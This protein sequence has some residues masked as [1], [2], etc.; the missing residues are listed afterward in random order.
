M[1]PS[2]STSESVCAPSPRH[3]SAFN[4]S[5]FAVLDTDGPLPIQSREVQWTTGENVEARMLLRLAEEDIASGS[6]EQFK[7]VVALMNE[8]ATD[9]AAETPDSLLIMRRIAADLRMSAINGSLPPDTRAVTRSFLFNCVMKLSSKILSQPNKELV[10]ESVALLAC[11]ASQFEDWEESY[12]ILRKQ[13]ILPINALYEES[14][15]SPEIVSLFPHLVASISAFWLSPVSQVR[16]ASVILGQLLKIIRILGNSHRYECAEQSL[17]SLL[18]RLR[19]PEL[20]PTATSAIGELLRTAHEKHGDGDP[21]SF[22]FFSKIIDPMETMKLAGWNFADAA[23]ADVWAGSI[24]CG[25]RIISDTFPHVPKPLRG[26]INAQAFGR[27]DDCNEAVLGRAQNSFDL[28][29]TEL[30][31]FPEVRWWLT[32][33][34][35]LWTWFCAVDD[36]EVRKEALGRQYQATRRVLGCRDFSPHDHSHDARPGS[37]SIPRSFTSTLSESTVVDFEA[38]T[39]SDHHSSHTS[40]LLSR[41]RPS[42][43]AHIQMRQR[44]SSGSTLASVPEDSE[45]RLEAVAM[46]PTFHRAPQA[47]SVPSETLRTP[48][49]RQHKHT[50]VGVL[51]STSRTNTRYSPIRPS[52]SQSAPAT[53]SSSRRSKQRSQSNPPPSEMTGN[54]TMKSPSHGPEKPNSLKRGHPL[55]S[56]MKENERDFVNKRARTS[57]DLT[58]MKSPS[59]RDPYQPPASSDAP[60]FFQKLTRIGSRRRK[61][62]SA[63]SA[64]TRPEAVAGPSRIPS[65]ETT[66]LSAFNLPEVPATPRRTRD[67]A[68]YSLYTPQ[69]PGSIYHIEDRLK[70]DNGWVEGL[71][72]LWFDSTAPVDDG[73]VRGSQEFVWHSEQ[74]SGEGQPHPVPSSSAIPVTHHSIAGRLTEE[75]DENE[76]NEIGTPSAAGILSTQSTPTHRVTRMSTPFFGSNL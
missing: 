68:A 57:L 51:S 73:G 42:S 61:S 9:P 14:P 39:E 67:H 7:R 34:A 31:V 59:S 41:S 20:I 21:L 27:C 45:E 52:Y 54:T 3:P 75:T 23:L 72:K 71:T 29:K 22:K 12:A 55:S 69:A 25:T 37:S 36:E 16:R 44:V 63:H 32:K 46:P 30:Q 15:D 19:D 24:K 5:R 70:H 65:L 40:A 26:V 58:L 60:S 28:T 13:I 43:N 53:P 50:A 10:V 47:P 64:T 33:V 76:E 56:S 1:L 62:G 17:K 49:T 48:G 4:P 8:I 66:L 2:L 38:A 11:I 6:P 74:P 35:R 18:M